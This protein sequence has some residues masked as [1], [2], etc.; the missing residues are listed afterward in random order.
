MKDTDVYLTV[1]FQYQLFIHNPST[2]EHILKSA[3][4][5]LNTNF[6]R[7]PN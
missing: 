3:L 5:F 7:Q 6:A 4:S 1:Y 2:L